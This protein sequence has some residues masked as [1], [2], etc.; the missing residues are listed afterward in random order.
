MEL[1][2]ALVADHHRPGA[3]IARLEVGLTAEHAAA[4]CTAGLV[5]LLNILQQGV[6]LRNHLVEGRRRLRVVVV[7][8]RRRCRL[9]CCG[10]SWCGGG[11]E[12]LLD[13]LGDLPVGDR[14]DQR[15]QCLARLGPADGF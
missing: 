9:L 2:V 11:G 5:P 7:P 6:A 8:R 1:S 12:E 13:R 14:V 3:K 4:V 10:R 15:P